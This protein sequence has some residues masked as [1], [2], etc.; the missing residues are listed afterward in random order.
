MKKSL[1]IFLLFFT[2]YAQL[3][4][5]M[6]SQISSKTYTGEFPV[7]INGGNFIPGVYYAFPATR[8]LDL[9][10]KATDTLAIDDIPREITVDDKTIDLLKY[11]FNNDLDNN[12]TVTPGMT[13]YVRFPIEHVSIKGD[14]L[15]K[16]SKVAIH[17]N[18]KLS[19]FIKLFT[20]SPT[21]D[22]SFITL[23]RDNAS[24]Q[25]SSSKYDTILLKNNDFVIVPENKSK[26]PPCMVEIKGEADKPG[27]YAIE[28]GKTRLKDILP[29]IGLLPTANISKICIYRKLK[30]DQ[31]QSPR[32]EVTAGLK[33][34]A[35]SHT[36]FYADSEQILNDKDIIEIPKTDHFVYINGFVKNPSSI[37]YTEGLLVRDYIK[38][39]GGFSKSADKVNVRVITAC[40]NNYQIKDIK[41]VQ[42]GDVILVPESSES[43]WIKTWT[44]I[45]SVI[46][47]TASIIAAVI[48]LSK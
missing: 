27:F 43:K 46:G 7:T 18:E 15:N 1:L 32:L 35:V 21:A 6:T 26:L 40:G 19:D 48:N 36:T 12:P 33:N 3:P 20:L 2:S 29:Q 14:I 28:H 5:Q 37:E 41:E 25:I 47:S 34:L 8:V 42:P 11:I 10:R 38:K 30:V 22:S 13:I 45:I 9:L 44:P 24:L 23:I 39:A 16:V 4:S 17:N 31:L